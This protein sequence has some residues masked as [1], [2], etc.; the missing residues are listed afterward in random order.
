MIYVHIPK[1]HLMTCPN[2]MSRNVKTTSVDMSKGHPNKT[3]INKTDNNKG[4]KDAVK[5]L[6]KSEVDTASSDVVNWD[7]ARKNIE[8]IRAS[9]RGG[10]DA[11][12]E[13]TTENKAD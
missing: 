2:D 7:I 10:A 8:R 11:A 3:Y 12:T 13:N 9:M 1:E 5:N 6:F 4:H